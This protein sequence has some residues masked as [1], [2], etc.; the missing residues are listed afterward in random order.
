MNFDI[1]NI[2]GRKISFNS[3]L[4]KAGRNDLKCSNNGMTG[5]NFA[6]FNVGKRIIQGPYFI[7]KTD[8]PVFFY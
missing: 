6:T 4:I 5:T 7:I 3:V 2:A 8:Q 1:G